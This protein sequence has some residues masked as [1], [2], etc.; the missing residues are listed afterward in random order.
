ML[1]IVQKDPSGYYEEQSLQVCVGAGRSTQTHSLK[2]LCKGDQNKSAS[3]HLTECHGP[4]ACCT[5]QVRLGQGFSVEALLTFWATK[6]CGVWGLGVVL[7][8]VGCVAVSLTSTHKCRSTPSHCDNQKCLQMWQTS[9]VGE[10]SPLI[11]TR[12]GNAVRPK[13]STF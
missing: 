12:T 3:F 7:C 8:T 11:R 1:Y 13:P 6:F 4:F 5:G 9:P 2:M 10:R